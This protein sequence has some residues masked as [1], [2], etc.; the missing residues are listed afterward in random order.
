M[1]AHFQALEA[2]PLPAT[3]LLY[4]NKTLLHKSSELSSL[5]TGPGL[6]SS[7][8][9]AKNPS[10]FH[11]SAATFHFLG[12]LLDTSLTSLILLRR[13]QLSVNYFVRGFALLNLIK[14]KV[15]RDKSNKMC[16]GS[17]C[18]KLQTNERNHKRS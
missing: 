15:L 11:G 9:E 5:V 2:V 6:D 4:F 12:Q 14:C 18:R 1:R 16:K 10:V 7:P 13:I 17:V 8:L 3:S